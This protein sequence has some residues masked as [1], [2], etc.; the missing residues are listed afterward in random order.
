MAAV[1]TGI[2][3]TGL[4]T[5]KFVR[6]RLS[7][8]FWW[9]T[10]GTPAF[11]VYSAAAIANYGIAATEVGVTGVYTASDPAETTPG[12]YLFVKAAGAS[13]AVA[14]LTTGL[15]WQ[16][17]VSGVVAA[18]VTQLGGD[19]QSLADLKDFADTGYNPS[20][21]SVALVDG[22][23]ALSLPIYTNLQLIIPTA[24][25]NAAAWGASVVGNGRTRDYYLQGG[26][27]A[28]AFAAD[29]LTFTVM[30]ADDVTP[31]Y[32]G[33]ATRLATTVGGL[34]SIDPA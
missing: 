11:E 13:L 26:V 29:G 34:R 33:T 9:N 17:G 14:D 21:H 27:N 20:T 25:Q 22:V 6:R 7:D 23:T 2:A 18:N 10:S 32:T 31:L 15:R 24:A 12:D 19:A 3:E 28:I 16:D 1:M 4:T 30:A 8:G 5:G